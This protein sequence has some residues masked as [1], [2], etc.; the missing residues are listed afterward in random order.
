M[1][2]DADQIEQHAELAACFLRALLT[3]SIPI[4][5]AVQA[6]ADVHHDA[7]QYRCPPGEAERSVGRRTA[8]Q[9]TSTRISLART[10]HFKRGDTVQVDSMNGPVSRQRIT[11]ITG[12]TITLR[13]VHRSRVLEWLHFSWENLLDWRHMS[14]SYKVRFALA[15]LAM[16]AFVSCVATAQNAPHITFT[17]PHLTVPAYDT[18]TGVIASPINTDGKKSGTSRLAWSSNP[19]GALS[20]NS[21]DKYWQKVSI[22]AES[23]GQRYAIATWI[24][25]DRLVVRDSLAIFVGPPTTSITPFNN[26]LQGQIIFDPLRL[27]DYCLY[28]LEIDRRGGLHTGRAVTWATDDTVWGKLLN[29]SQ[30][31][32]TSSLPQLTFFKTTVP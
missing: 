11:R 23:P 15:V 14:F 16:I 6:H 29:S 21:S 25:S 1:K 7:D 27:P 26:Y 28:P 18:L 30:C 9:M 24:R 4:Q 17:A 20:I 5:A 12:Q 19:P 13:P 32:D 3:K 8:A 2:I 10:I 31:P 22:A